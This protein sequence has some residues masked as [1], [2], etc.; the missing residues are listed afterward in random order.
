[1]T[2]INLFSIIVWGIFGHTPII[3]H[4]YGKNLGI[5]KTNKKNKTKLGLFFVCCLP[6]FTVQYVS[7]L[8]S[9]TVNFDIALNKHMNQ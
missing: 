3:S 2:G 7:I 4:R 9:V 6:V 5:L 8:Y 1:M